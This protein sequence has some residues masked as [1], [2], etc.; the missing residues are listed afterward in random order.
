M[1]KYL[2][3]IALTWVLSGCAAT[4]QSLTLPEVPEHL[5]TSPGELTTAADD[6]PEAV[7]RAHQHNMRICGVC[8]ERHEGLSEAIRQRQSIIDEVL[9]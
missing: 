6:T 1:W 3:L 9:D 8:L 5:M 2:C 7:F 4:T